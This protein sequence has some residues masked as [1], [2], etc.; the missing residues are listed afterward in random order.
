M[1]AGQRRAVIVDTH[2][3]WKRLQ[4]THTIDTYI[5][6]SDGVETTLNTRTFTVDYPDSAALKAKALDAVVQDVIQKA[7]VVKVPVT[8]VSPVEAQVDQVENEA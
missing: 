6:D 2:V 7:S 3:D 1:A 8:L 4:V 5:E